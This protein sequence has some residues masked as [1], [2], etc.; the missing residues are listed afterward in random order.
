MIV[1]MMACEESSVTRPRITSAEESCA[2]TGCATRDRSAMPIAIAASGMRKDRAHRLLREAIRSI[3]VEMIA[4]S[5]GLLTPV[6]AGPLDR[7]LPNSLLRL[8]PSSLDLGYGARQSPDAGM[9][10]PSRFGA[11]KAAAEVS[12]GRGKKGSAWRRFPFLST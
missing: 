3:R 10:F 1:A 5:S 11:R 6:R 4:V 8:L 2:E 12:Q 7:S 9:T